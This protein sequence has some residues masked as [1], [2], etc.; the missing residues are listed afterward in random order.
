[1]KYLIGSIILLITPFL[2]IAQNADFDGRNVY[3]ISRGIGIE[4]YDPVAY[5]VKNQAIKGSKSFSLNYQKITYY[6]S[7]EKNK[8]LFQ[9]N[10]QKYL[11]Q[12]GGWCAYAMGEDGKKVE[13]NPKTFKI[14]NNKLYLFYNAFFNNTLESWNKNEA[15]LKTNADRNWQ[16]YLTGN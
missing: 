6:F 14:V 12:Y 7:E 9:A 8:A 2:L 15:Q 3:N 11:P 1:M 10:P 5:F 16:K 13:I 4:G